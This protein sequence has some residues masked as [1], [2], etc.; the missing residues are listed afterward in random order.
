MRK[1]WRPTAKVAAICNIGDPL[2]TWG[3][4]DPGLHFWS[5]TGEELGVIPDAHD[6]GI[7]GLIR[8]GDYLVSWGRPSALTIRNL[9]GIAVET[10]SP[11]C[12]I[13]E[14]VAHSDRII[15]RDRSLWVYCLDRG[16]PAS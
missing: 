10:I 16:E 3:P 12:G 2:V 14:V 15:V 8:A 1:S 9:E 13:S 6:W 4:H 11:P 7:N 5:F